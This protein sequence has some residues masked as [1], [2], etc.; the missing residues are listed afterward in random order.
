MREQERKARMGAKER[1]KRK[2]IEKCPTTGN[3][4]KGYPSL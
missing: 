1:S 2:F 3:I 4:K